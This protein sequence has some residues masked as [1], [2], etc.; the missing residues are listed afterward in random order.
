MPRHK[1]Q[2]KNIY[3]IDWRAATS[4]LE[5][6]VWLKRWKSISSVLENVSDTWIIQSIWLRMFWII[7]LFETLSRCVWKWIIQS[8]IMCV[9]ECFGYL[10]Y[11]KHL[12]ENV[13]NYW[14]IWNL[15]PS[16]FENELFNIF[17]W[18]CLRMFWIIWNLC[19]SVF[20]TWLFKVS[21]NVC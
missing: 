2:A 9:G 20:E 19:P 7:E 15:C 12:F 16:V 17:D 4:F 21:H 13:L 3:Y 14:I 18:V 10:N 6:V 8:L 5:S 11:S 1:L